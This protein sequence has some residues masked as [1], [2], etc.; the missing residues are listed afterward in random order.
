MT[1]CTIVEFEW[2]DPSGRTAL[3]EAVGP[4]GGAPP[5]GCRSRIVSI[6]DDGAR[7]IEVWESSEAAR[8]HAESSAPDTSAAGMPQASRVSGFEVTDYFAN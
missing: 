6:D 2:S 5:S 7:V 3:E 4:T 8:S 1:Y